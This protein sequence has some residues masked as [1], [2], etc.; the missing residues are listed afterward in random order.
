MPLKIF[1]SKSGDLLAELSSYSVSHYNVT[2][3]DIIWAIWVDAPYSSPDDQSAPFTVREINDDGE[4]RVFENGWLKDV[5][6]TRPNIAVRIVS[7][8]KDS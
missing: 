5:S 7:K 6:G 1:D 4:E 2:D 8:G 3:D